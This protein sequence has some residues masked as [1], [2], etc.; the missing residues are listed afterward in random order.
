MKVGRAG[1]GRLAWLE[2]RP[3]TPRAASISSL[4]PSICYL[5]R[6]IAPRANTTVPVIRLPFD[7]EPQTAHFLIEKAP[8]VYS[9]VSEKR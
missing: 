6:A 2:L 7:Y 5:F 9:Q 8:L 4:E 3:G 1:A